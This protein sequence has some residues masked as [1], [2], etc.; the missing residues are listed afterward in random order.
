MNLVHPICLSLVCRLARL[1]L[2]D[3][4]LL[5][6]DEPTNHLD[7]SARQWLGE[8]VG[9][10]AGTVLVVSHDEGFVSAAA[11]S[12]AEVSLRHEQALRS[13]TE[14]TVYPKFELQ[15]KCSLS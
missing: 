8:Y 7:A 12:I 6:L 13:Q 4:E 14:Q 2:S 11:D 5:I 10:Y 15:W 1:L 9:S 3:P